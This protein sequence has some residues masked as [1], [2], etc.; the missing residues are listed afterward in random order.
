MEKTALINTACKDLM[1][2]GVWNQTARLKNSIK[3]IMKRPGAAAE[4]LI[5]WPTGLLAHGLWQCRKEPGTERQ[6]E[7]ALASYFVRW[8]KKGMPVYYLDD[9]LYVEALLDSYLSE[10][11]EQDR[12]KYRKA[13]DKMADYAMR[14]PVDETGSFPYRV[15]LKNAIEHLIPPLLNV[16]KP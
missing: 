8:Q 15:F 9:L 13:V 12:E 1:S 14:Y 10:E 16:K 5:F 4:D 7:E 2:Y 3:K 6:V 11:A